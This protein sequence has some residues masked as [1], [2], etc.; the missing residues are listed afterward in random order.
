MG[1]RPAQVL[2]ASLLG[3]ALALSSAA[4]RGETDAEKAAR[5]FK[6]G[7]KAM[8][9]KDPASA[10]PKFSESHRLAPAPGTLLNLALCEEALG[11]LASALEDMKKVLDLLPLEDERAKFARERA[12]AIEPTVPRVDV[13][14]VAGAPP[15]TSIDRDGRGAA[16]VRKLPRPLLVD[17]GDHL[18]VVTAPGR[19]PRRYPIS[20][21][22]T[23]R[24]FDSRGPMEIG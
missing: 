20:P 9:A 12:A 13:T 17:A 2:L 15:E 1:T 19:A 4:A 24:L 18:F 6:E 7:R 11:K 8:T 3:S 5:L 22:S 14:L 21:G 10:C 23:A 16:E